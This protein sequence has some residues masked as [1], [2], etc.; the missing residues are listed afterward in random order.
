MPPTPLPQ[1][2]LCAKMSEGQGRNTCHTRLCQHQGYEITTQIQHLQQHVK[3]FRENAAENLST[4]VS[5][6][7]GAEALPVAC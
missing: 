4:S 1:R 3:V 6:H 7:R 5:V 2:S